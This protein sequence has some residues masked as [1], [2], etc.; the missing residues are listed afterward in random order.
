MIKPWP[1]IA[2]KPAGDFRIFT[3]RDEQK[4]S[5]RTGEPHDFYVIDCVNWVNVIATTSDQQLVMIEQYRHGTDTVELEIP[6]GMMD[7][8]ENSPVATGLRELREETGYEGQNA[9]LIGEIFP[10][11]AIMSNTCYTVLVENC[12]LKHPT[13][14]D[15]GEDMINRLMPIAEIPRL[16]ADG[17]IR[18]AMVV[19]ALY[20]FELWR[21]GIKSSGK[22]SSCET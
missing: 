22:F 18:H 14:F 6:G 15:H 17:R 1:R 13:E 8:H 21:R 2:S 11:P 16:I 19:V 4:R 3:I 20:H 7:A 12:E 9:R 5:P 10:N